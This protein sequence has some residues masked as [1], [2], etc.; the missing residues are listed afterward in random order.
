VGQPGVE[1]RLSQLTL[2]NNSASLTGADLYARGGSVLVDYST[3]VHAANSPSIAI[4]ASTSVSL[5]SS[6]LYAP[7]SPCLLLAGANIISRGFNVGKTADCM[8]NQTSDINI[9][10]LSALVLSP[11]GDYGGTQFGFLPL[12]GSPVLDRTTCT[13]LDAR[14]APRPVN[15]TG[16]ATALCDSGAF[17]RQLRE[18]FVIFRDGFE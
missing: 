12:P 10:D 17:E 1:T 14:G 2:T 18:P 11:F 6:V 7:G 13:G 16:A 5:A 3:F 8:L 15:I 9:T 4:E